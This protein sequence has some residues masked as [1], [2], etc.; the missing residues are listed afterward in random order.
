MLVL[1][2]TVC[3]LAPMDLPIVI[4]RPLDEGRHLVRL[5]YGK[6]GPP[7]PLHRC[8]Y[9]WSIYFS[10]ICK[11]A[12]RIDGNIGLAHLIDIVIGERLC[13]SSFSPEVIWKGRARI[14]S[15]HQN[16]KLCL[17]QHNIAPIGFRSAEGPDAL[18]VPIKTPIAAIDLEGCGPSQPRSVRQTLCRSRVWKGCA[19]IGSKHQ[20]AKF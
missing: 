20:N 3:P 7:P 4:G 11:L 12:S 19:R 2:Q 5:V 18:Q 9:N 15:K 16:A 8:L 1:F 10:A 14:G 17:V 13:S 6:T